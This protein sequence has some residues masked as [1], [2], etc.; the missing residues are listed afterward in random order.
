MGLVFVE[1]L[2]GS[3]W[4]SVSNLSVTAYFTFYGAIRP[5]YKLPVMVYLSVC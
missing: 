1:L 2:I 5:S 3:G 4:A